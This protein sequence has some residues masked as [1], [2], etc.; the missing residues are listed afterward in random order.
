MKTTTG[1]DKQLTQLLSTMLKI[2]IPSSAEFSRPPL[3]FGILLFRT[4]G[5]PNYFLILYSVNI[6]ISCIFTRKIWVYCTIYGCQNKFI[7]AKRGSKFD[8]LLQT[9]F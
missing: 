4:E 7:L 2:C 3:K 1:I 6:C 8:F 5:Y 9:K